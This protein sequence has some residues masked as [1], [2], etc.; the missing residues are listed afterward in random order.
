MAVVVSLLKWGFGFNAQGYTNYENYRIFRNAFLHLCQE[1]N[2]YSSFPAEQWDLFKYSPAFALA[3]APFTL[4]PDWAGLCLWNL[5]NAL[6]LLYAFFRLPMLKPEQ[7]ALCAW[8]VLPELVIS[9]QNSQSN[10][11]TAGLLLLAFAAFER[12]LLF[13]AA[14]WVAGAAFIKIFGLLAAGMSLLYPNRFRFSVWMVVWMFFLGAIPFLFFQTDYV[15]HL[16]QWWGE[17][18]RNDHSASVGL[19][20]HGWLISWFGWFLPKN[21][22]ALV[23]LVLF[24]ASVAVVAFVKGANTPLNRLN[25]WVALLLWVVIFN[26]KAE[27]PTFVIALCGAALWYVAASPSRWHDF[28]FFLI[29]LFASL[30][31]TDIFPA[32]IRKTFVEPF[33]L[34]AVPCIVL[35]I[36][37]TFALLCKRNLFGSALKE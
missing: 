7:A 14:G 34:K 33:V 32:G 37:I 5:L 3:M 24:M 29:F 16:Y 11:L 1:S 19:S 22:V 20:V 26:H 25:V 12:G 8:L 30:S 18:L 21:A 27:S 4:L 9:M 23:G 10:G 15:L 2:I 28:L 13:R 31:P 17:L 35:W 36:I 6:P